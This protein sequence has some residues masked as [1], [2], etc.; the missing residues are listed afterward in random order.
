MPHFA[1]L[2]VLS[3]LALA[4]LCPTAHADAQPLAVQLD[5]DV[6]AGK[7]PTL[8]LTAA[9]DLGRLSLDLVRVGGRDDGSHF[10]HALPALR[11]GGSASIE[12]P[13]AAGKTHWRGRLDV[14]LPEPSGTDGAWAFDLDFETL[15]RAP[16][17][18][19]WDHAH[20]DLNGHVLRFRQSRAAGRAELEVVGEDGQV[21]GRGSASYHGEKAGT[22]LELPWTQAPGRAL[23]LRLHAT[24]KDGI[25][26]GAELSPWSLAIEHEDVRFDTGSAVL[27]PEELPRLDASLAKIVEAARRVERF[28]TLRLYVAGHTDTVG[29]AD[30]NRALSLARARAIAGYFREHGLALPIVYAG[31]GEEVPR[32]QTAD[33]VDEPAN[34][35]VDYVL[36]PAEG[37]PPFPAAYRRARVTWQSVQ[38]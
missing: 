38:P 18:L 25:A 4:A 21:I 7:K 19:E 20:L 3:A 6:P 29:R 33:Q 17:K 14:V 23:L 22:W 32:V 24:A 35:R 27:R 13:G 9:R 37:A 34:R 8:R 15:V 12:L 1:R 11:S 31:F 16:M 26:A 30:D 36:G 2:A 10:V 5:A 28:V